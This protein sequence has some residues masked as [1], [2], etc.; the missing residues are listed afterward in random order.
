L[1]EDLFAFNR[2]VINHTDSSGNNLMN[3]RLHKRLCDFVSHRKKNK[4]LILLPIGSFKTSCVTV[5]FSLQQ[6]CKNPNITILLDSEQ[7]SKA[8]DY[9]N[10][11][12]ANFERNK[13]LKALFGNFVPQRGWREDQIVVSKRTKSL[14]E[15]TVATSGIDLPATERHF[16]IIIIDDLVSNQNVNTPEQRRKVLNH[17]KYILT[18]V[19]DENSLIIVVGTRWHYQDLYS[20][21]LEKMKDS[22]DSLILSAEDKEGNLLFP[23]KLSRK[24]LDD[25]KRR[26]GS[27]YSALYL[28]EPVVSENALFKKEWIKYYKELPEDLEVQFYTAV[29]PAVST[30]DEA[31]NY[32][33]ITCAQDNM[34][35][36]YVEDLRCGH[37][38]P[39]EGISHIIATK[40]LYNP[41]K[42]GIETN[43]FQTYIKHNLQKELDARRLYMNIVE[44]SHFG[45]KSKAQ[46]IE[47]LE[48]YFK[49]GDILIKEGIEELEEELLSYPKGR[50]DVLDALAMILELL[51][52]RRSQSKPLFLPKRRVNAIIGGY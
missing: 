19:V 8:V 1:L 7:K 34:G 24:F 22:F 32:V 39:D 5:G 3:V 46:R 47:A 29:D 27:M 12:K 20:W 4:L 35:K 14:K 44:L 9:L 51:P 36:L 28:N 42:V 17:F 23:E 48:P 21:I 52:R 10:E 11:I 49:A 45:K 40:L 33:V 50:D 18:R 2:W 31:D 37:F 41:R 15:P 43:T 30:S 25:E 38:T 26:L 16:N 13:R 6:V